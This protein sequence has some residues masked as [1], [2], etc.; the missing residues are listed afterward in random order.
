MANKKRRGPKPVPKAARAAPKAPTAGAKARPPSPRAGRGGFA[1]QWWVVIGVVLGAGVIGLI[2]QASRSESE[3]AKVVVPTRSMGPRGSEIEG[4]ASAPVLVEEYA[5]F[6][7]PTCRQFHAVTGPT[8]ARLVREGKIRFAYHYFP[9]LGDESY[10]A[11]AAAVCAGDAGKF[12]PY[13]DLLYDRQQ[14]ENSGFLTTDRLV[15]FGRDVGL[16]GSELS[17][18]ERC[19]RSNR[20]EGW[21]R[22]QTEQASKRGIRSTPTVFVNGRE[23]SLAESLDPS[24]FEQ[25]VSSASG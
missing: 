8:V 11:A 9:F 19:V 20:Y 1:W 5:D 18:F 16:R 13:A 7:C 12:F 21:V 25:I 6:Q 23:L 15:G 14:A 10:R 2:V 22:K 24:T 4:D 17:E 3:H